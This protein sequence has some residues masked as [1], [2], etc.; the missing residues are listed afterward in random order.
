MFAAKTKLNLCAFG[1]AAELPVASPSHS[2][3]DLFARGDTAGC[4]YEF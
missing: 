4:S 2:F 1:C 3:R